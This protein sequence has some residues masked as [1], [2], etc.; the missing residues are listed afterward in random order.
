MP[1]T[2]QKKTSSE[3]NTKSAVKIPHNFIINKIKKQESH[4]CSVTAQTYSRLSLVSIIINTSQSVTLFFVVMKLDD[5][6]CLDRLR[7]PCLG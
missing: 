5:G 1:L 7:E 4:K 6:A 3:K 2:L